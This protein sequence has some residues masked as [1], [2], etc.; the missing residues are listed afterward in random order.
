MGC[1][2]FNRAADKRNRRGRNKL[3]SKINRAA[4]KTKERQ[5]MENIDFKALFNSPEPGTIEQ[6]KAQ[7]PYVYHCGIQQ[8]EPYRQR[9]RKPYTREELQELYSTKI[10]AQAKQW[11]VDH[12]YTRLCGLVTEINLKSFDEGKV[13]EIYR[14]QYA[15]DGEQ[16]EKYHYSDGTS[17]KCWLGLND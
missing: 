3:H 13:V 1:K 8:L 11:G 7:P 10:A 2:R 17:V 4:N 6:Q 12:Y 5:H 14:E 16:Y 9:E 15:E